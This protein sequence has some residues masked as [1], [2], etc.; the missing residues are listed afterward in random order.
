MR[1]LAQ[2][3]PRTY[4]VD[5]LVSPFHS[6]EGAAPRNTESNSLSGVQGPWE[7]SAALHMA[8]LARAHPRAGFSAASVLEIHPKLTPTSGTRADP[9]P[10][11]LRGSVGREQL[12]IVHTPHMWGPAFGARGYFTTPSSVG[13]SVPSSVVVMEE[14]GREA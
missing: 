10:S 8:G 12:L 4:S 13:T 1:H 5:T 9:P 14:A 7:P 3:F 6:Q 11:P 2:C